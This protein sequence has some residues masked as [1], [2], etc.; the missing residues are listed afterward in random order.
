MTNASTTWRIGENVPWSVSWTDEE[1]FSLRDS[2]DFPGL[3]DLV[4][5]ERPGSGRPKF[6]ALNVTRQRLGIIGQLCHICGRRTPARDRYIFPV[7]SGGFVAVGETMRYAGTVPPVHLACG[8]RARTL[9]PHLSHALADPV[10]YPSEDS[11]VVPR[12]DVPEGMA[13]LARSLPRGQ[14]IVY[15]CLRIY[16]PRFSR[17]VERMRKARGGRSA[18]SWREF[19]A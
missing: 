6:A 7:E 9:C 8:K 18:E 3:V 11:E 1:S 13:A 10:A 16:G 14:K 17:T 12:P 5:I 2:S 15:A 4:Q 19:T